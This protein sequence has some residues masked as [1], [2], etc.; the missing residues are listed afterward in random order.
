[1]KRDFVIEFFSGFI[2]FGLFLWFALS[3]IGIAN[4]SIYRE[5]NLILIMYN[6]FIGG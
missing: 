1:M 5:W 2:L 4:N 3:C 6:L